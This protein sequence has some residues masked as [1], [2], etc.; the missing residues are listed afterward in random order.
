MEPSAF[1]KRKVTEMGADLKGS[2]CFAG[3]NSPDNVLCF[4]PFFK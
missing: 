1:R 3:R 4:R 2:N